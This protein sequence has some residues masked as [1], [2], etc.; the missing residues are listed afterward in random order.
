MKKILLALLVS[1]FTITVSAQCIQRDEKIEAQV[2]EILSKMTLDDKVGQMC[3][4][5][6]DKVAQKSGDN[7][8]KSNKSMQSLAN[9]M[10]SASAVDEMFG[11]YKVGS[12]LNVPEGVAQ[13]PKVWAEIIRALNNSSAFWTNGIPELYGVDQ[14]HGAS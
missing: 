10:L 2:E 7:N 8:V 4:L 14:I 1:L 13:T 9:G 3:E 6:I 12:I 5:A 11:K